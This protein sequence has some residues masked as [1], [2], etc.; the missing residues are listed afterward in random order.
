MLWIG[1]QLSTFG[2]V[3]ALFLPSVISMVV[4][5]FFLSFML[6]GNFEPKKINFQNKQVEPMGELV[7]FLGVAALIFVPI[8][9][10][11]TGLPPFMGVLFGLSVLWLVTDIAHGLLGNRDDLRMPT[12]LTRIDLSSLLFFWGFY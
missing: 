2:V 11:L 10:I 8:F 12:V 1:G 6:K 3:R 5:V 4:A 7:F 9:K